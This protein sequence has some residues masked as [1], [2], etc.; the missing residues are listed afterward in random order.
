MKNQRPN[1]EKL[2]SV[3]KIKKNHE[4]LTHLEKGPH[5]H[6]I[7]TICKRRSIDLLPRW[8]VVSVKQSS[9]AWGL[10]WGNAKYEVTMWDWV[11]EIRFRIKNRNYDSS[12]TCGIRPP[13]GVQSQKWSEKL[14]ILPSS[15]QKHLKWT[16]FRFCREIML[17]EHFEITPD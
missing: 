16:H 5:M 6:Q 12:W 2:K 11:A 1:L 17:F 10:I 13:S 9:A 14:K 8:R 4:K 15:A 7:L 3:F